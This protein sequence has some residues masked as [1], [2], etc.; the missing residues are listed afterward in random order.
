MPK[1]QNRAIVTLT[2]LQVPGEAPAGIC[3]TCKNSPSL[4]AR[5]HPLLVVALPG[6]E[7]VVI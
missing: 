6:E 2:S 4:W 5:Q 3:R 1:L 7:G